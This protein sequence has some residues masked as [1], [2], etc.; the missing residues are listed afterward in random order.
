MRGS[1]G[2]DCDMSCGRGDI[3]ESY[4]VVRRCGEWERGFTYTVPGQIDGGEDHLYEVTSPATGLY[5]P[6]LRFPAMGESGAIQP[7]RVLPP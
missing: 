7:D 3:G 5:I 6:R 2:L 1:A 4:S